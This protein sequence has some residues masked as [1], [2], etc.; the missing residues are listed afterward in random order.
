MFNTGFAIFTIGSALCGLALSIELLVLFRAI[1][2]IGGLFIHAN[3]RAVIADIFP[4]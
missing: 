1:Q 4:P 3:S 2:A